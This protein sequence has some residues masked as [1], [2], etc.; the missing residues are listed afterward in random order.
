MKE[1]LQREKERT[2]A[3]VAAVNGNQ[4]I[5]ALLLLENA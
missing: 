5:A 2:A 4:R 3:A 1:D